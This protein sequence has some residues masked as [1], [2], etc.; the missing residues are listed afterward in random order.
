V[1]IAALLLPLQQGKSNWGW[2]GSFGDVGLVVAFEPCKKVI[3]NQL[4]AEI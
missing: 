4:W 2:M 3:P 1:F